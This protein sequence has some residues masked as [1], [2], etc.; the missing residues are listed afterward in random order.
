MVSGKRPEDIAILDSQGFD[1]WQGKPWMEAGDLIVMYRTAPYSDISYVL[2]AAGKARK[3]KGWDHDYKIKIAGGYRLSRTIKYSELRDD[4]L[5]EH[6]NFVKTAHGATQQKEDLEAK[7]IWR[8]LSRRIEE[9]SPGI[10]SYFGPVW[11]GIGKRKYVFL[12]YSSPNARQAEKIRNE[13]MQR[14]IDVWFDKLELHAG[15]D[16]KKKINKA[17]AEASAFVV[18]ISKKW[19]ERLDHFAQ[20]ELETALRITKR[21]KKFI[22]PILIEDCDIPENL[23]SPHAMRVF[24]NHK[25]VALND[26]VAELQKAR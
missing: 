16:W 14:R 18:C 2:V 21:K 22:L 23:K 17:I 13:L 3:V 7:D 15:D 4:P 26:L 10:S 8:L 19:K 11:A 24:G 12:S 20:E 1:T 25:R 5:L 9:R 6:W